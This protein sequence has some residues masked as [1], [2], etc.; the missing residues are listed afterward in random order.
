MRG[1]RGRRPGAARAGLPRQGRRRRGA[2]R[3]RAAGAR[4]RRS[5]STR[6]SPRCGRCCAASSSTS[7]RERLTC[8]RGYAATVPRSSLAVIALLLAYRRGRRARRHRACRRRRTRGRRWPRS[9]PPVPGLGA[10]VIG[11]DF[12][13]RLRLP[14]G[15][16]VTVNR[17]GGARPLH[18]RGGTLT[19]REHR[20]RHPRPDGSC[21]SASRSTARPWW[22]TCSAARGSAPAPWVPLAAGGDRAAA[23]GAW[24]PR[25]ASGAGRERVR[26]DADRRGRRAAGRARGGGGGRRCVVVLVL[27]L[28]AALA[29]AAVPERFRQLTAGGLAATSL[30]LAMAQVPMLYRAFPV[31]VLP[32]ALRVAARGGGAGAR[33][34]RAR[35]GRASRGRGGRSAWDVA[36]PRQWGNFT[37]PAARPL[38]SSLLAVNWHEAGDRS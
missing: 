27:S 37:G 28:L 9:R 32:D 4:R 24:R 34:R 33:R 30:L 36:V 5:S 2:V 10:E 19:W 6:R 22:S 7:P 14:D 26:G 21:R 13:L 11:N 29:L 20:L 18:A 8:S 35:G 3:G 17:I 12:E 16:D 23:I 1:D 38:C 15:A 31:S 25:L